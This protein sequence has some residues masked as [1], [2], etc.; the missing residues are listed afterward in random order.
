VPRRP[1]YS[2]GNG[3]AAGIISRNPRESVGI[4][5]ASGAFVMI[6]ANALFMQAGPH[7]APIFAPKANPAPGGARRPADTPPAPPPRIEAPARPRGQIV[8]DIQRELTR[9]HFYDGTADGIWG[10]KTDAAARDFAQAN[11]L[12]M[13]VEAGEDLLRAIAASGIPAAKAA[14]PEPARNDPIAQLL[15]PSKRVSAAQSILAAYGYG[16]IK[17]TGTLDPQTQDAIR[18]FE[19]SHKMPVTGQMSD[20]LV[21]ALSEM[22]GRPID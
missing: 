22:S 9:R 11:A 19:A 7:P 18:K 1:T 14:A 8:A 16:Q 15:A 21:R 3:S 6:C 13:P 20:Q 10:A 17:L 12:K 4:F 2:A 5:I